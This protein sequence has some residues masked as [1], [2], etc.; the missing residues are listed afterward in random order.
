MNLHS[1]V[2]GVVGVV[3]PNKEV[4][5]RRFVA[6]TQN[7]YYEKEATYI[8][9]I[10]KAQIQ[11]LTSYQ[12]KVMAYLKLHGEAY[13]LITSEVLQ[14]GSTVEQKG[15]DI[16]V[17]NEQDYLIVHVGETFHDHTAAIMVKQG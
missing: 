5:L 12:L 15:G 14:A 13:S 6:I 3:N 7:A 11:G 16:I 4:M 1:M 17:Y 10:I 8:D 9:I 2:V